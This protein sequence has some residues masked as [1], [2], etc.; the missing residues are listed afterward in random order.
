MPVDIP[1]GIKTLFLTEGTFTGPFKMI[2]GI[3]VK[4]S[5]DKTILTVGTGRVL[6]Q[7]TDFDEVT[8]WKDLTITGGQLNGENGAGAYI[9]KNGVLKNCNIHHNRSEGGSSQGGGVW[10]AEGS[11]LTQCRIH[12][13]FAQNAGGGVYSKGL[14]KYC[15]IEDNEAPDNVGGGIQLHG[16]STASNTNGTM[17]NCIVRRNSSKNAGGVRLYGNTQ[18]A[19]LLVEGNTATGGG[20]SGILSNGIASIVN[21]TIVK[22]YDDEGNVLKTPTRSKVYIVEDFPA[23]PL[24]YYTITFKIR[25]EVEKDETIQCTFADSLINTGVD[26]Q[27]QTLIG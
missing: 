12:D 2:E 16:G 27:K 10:A 8:T 26:K 6:I 11:I 15:T 19:N 17:F 21:C 14:V 20:I 25:T 22:N 18:V 9:R 5:G 23:D 3:D 24:G 7:E 4:G 1:E 13:N